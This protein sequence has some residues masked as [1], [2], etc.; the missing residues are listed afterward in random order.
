MAAAWS[1]TV[2]VYAPRSRRSSEPG[3]GG[4]DAVAVDIPDTGIR[5]TIMVDAA[6]LLDRRA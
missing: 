6:R 3:T 1:E 4:V 2:G 5:S